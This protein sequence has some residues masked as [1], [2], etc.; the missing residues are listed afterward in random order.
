MKKKVFSLLLLSA[1]MLVLA[2]CNFG[3]SSDKSSDSSKTADTKSEDKTLNLTIPSEPPSL[4]PQLATDSTSGAILRSVFEGLTRVD[5]DGNVQNAVAEDVKV[6]DDKLTYTFKLR[7]SK[8]TNGDPVVAGDFAYAWKWALDPKNASEYASILYPIKGAQAYNEGKGS[9]DDLGIKVI[10]DKTLEVTLENPTP[11]FLE[12]TA[13]YTYKPVNEK[14]AKANKKWA[15]DAGD[16]Y[17]TN[18]P[19]T[20]AEWKHSDSITLKKNPDYFDADNVALNTVN[21]KMVESETT[22]NRMFKSGD[23]DYLGS[24]FQTVPLDAIDGY[25]KD[26]TLNIEDYAAIY[27]YKFNTKGKYTSNQNIRKALTLAINREA[28]IKDVVKGEQTPALGMVPKAVK[29]FENQTGYI[30]DNDMAEAKKALA[31][32]MKEL[33]IKNASDI[34]IGISINTSEAHAAI[35]Q[36]IQEGWHKNLGIDVKID[37]SEWQVY[38]DKLT[39]LDYDVARL[40][41]IADYNDAYTFLERYDTA[42]NGNNDTGWE[43]PEYKALMQKAEKEVNEAKRLEYL[44]EGE[45]ILMTDMPVAPIYYYTNLN[46]VKDYVKN[47][48]P[49][50]LGEIDLKNVD[51]QK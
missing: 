49:N 35:A 43:N 15:S 44:K 8:W 17:V 25:K 30:K 13:F 40:G 47:M 50:K 3:G 19:F 28:L 11:Y 14:V 36:Y 1:L 41:W 23:I 16:N 39:A 9:A 31:A 5:K 21:I 20:L 45:K 48:T 18:G 4:N 7:D 34:K 10:D 37:N 29:G 33:G 2:A 42:K 26:K 51:I 27:E 38:L 22:A 6:S 12:L 46:V 24:P 32:G